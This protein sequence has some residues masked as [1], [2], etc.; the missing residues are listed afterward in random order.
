MRRKQWF[1]KALVI[2]NAVLL[3]SVFIAYKAGAFKS[4]SF[5][6][7]LKPAEL[8][9]HNLLAENANFRISNADSVKTDSAKISHDEQERIFMS[10]SKSAVVFTQAELDAMR[11]HLLEDETKKKKK[12]K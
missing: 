7:R 12:R 1:L 4:N 3:S 5:I 9:G 10:S 8:V 6:A 11:K 2:V